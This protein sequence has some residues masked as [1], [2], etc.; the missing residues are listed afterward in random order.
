MKKITTL[1]GLGMLLCPMLFAQTSGGPDAYG[2][3]WRDSNDPNGPT[4]NW[5]NIQDIG[6][7]VM[8]L[9]DD[10]S[11]SVIPMGMHF[12]YYWYDVN[13]MVLGSNGWI[14]F[15][16]VSNI[17]H[18]FPTIPV[19]GG[20]AD[21]YLAPFMTDLIF[22][23]AGTNAGMYYTYDSSN[24][25]FIIS[26]LNVPWWQQASPGYAGSNTFQVIFSAQDSS[27]TFQYKD[28]DQ[29]ALADNAGCF[30]DLIIGIEN[31]TGN[32]GMGLDQYIENVPADNYAIK[33]YPPDVALINI[34]DATPAWNQNEQNKGFFVESGVDF[35]L[36]TDIKNVGNT[37]IT[38]DIDVTVQVETLQS[39]QT[40]TGTDVIS[41]LAAG[42]NSTLSMAPA[43]NLS[44]GQY[45]FNTIVNNSSDVNPGNNIRVTEV[46]AVDLSLSNVLLSYATQNPPDG[47]VG[48]TGGGGMAVF[49][50]PPSFPADLNSVEA[51]VAPSLIGASEFTMEVLAPDGIDGL[52]GTVL[53]SVTVPAN[54]YTINSWVNVPL[55]TPV[56]LTSGGVYISFLHG[57]DGVYLGSETTG[58]ISRQ[59]YEFVGGTWAAYRENTTVDVLI[60]G[61]F[62]IVST[63]GVND[64]DKEIGLT[65][66]PNPNKGEFE[67][68]TEQIA[69][70]AEVEV[71][72][73]MGALIYTN[74]LSSQNRL[75]IDLGDIRSGIYLVKITDGD[76]VLTEKLV[77]H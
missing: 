10:N 77:V 11:S 48:W 39:A 8:G 38:T 1:L 7:Q 74:E 17:A 29:E 65:I 14:S 19:A 70:G 42:A 43:A 20:Q 22:N 68:H 30:S 41:G 56:E 9:T 25:R 51:F 66:F 55:N 15:D 60:N 28:M 46:N 64:L 49:M 52:P 53:E 18:C 72:N 58:P 27:I 21:N 35:V 2:Y 23:A 57:A 61:R 75:K 45:Y 71:W 44:P 34:P 6:I 32:I 26:Y 40:Y 13:E 16:N 33:F 76:R 62:D 3:V 5:L 63:I 47:N 73:T 31:I 69:T 54:S 12:H 59:T 36:Q 50:E 67:I 24:E 4:Y 37:D